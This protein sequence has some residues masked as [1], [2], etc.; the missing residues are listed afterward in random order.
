MALL[1]PGKVG[2]YAEPQ[3]DRIKLDS[4]PKSILEGLDAIGFRWYYTYANGAEP[5]DAGNGFDN[6]GT[7]TD[8]GYPP[9]YMAQYP[10]IWDP[11]PNY[12]NTTTLNLAK[13]LGG[14]LITYNE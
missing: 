8:P 11:Y 9:A 7:L 14:L 3:G 1:F 10:S 2:I 4:T 12:Q 5:Y 13:S 6:R